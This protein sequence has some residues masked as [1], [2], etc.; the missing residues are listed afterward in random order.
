[1][2]T[3]Q[4]TDQQIDYGMEELIPVVAE[5]TEK[6]TSAESS[7]VS[8]ERARHLIRRAGMQSDSRGVKKTV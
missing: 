4:K 1:M 3:E 6:F 2:N 7:S 8:Y 5:L